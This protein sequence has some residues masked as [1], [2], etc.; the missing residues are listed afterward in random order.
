MNL[1]DTMWTLTFAAL[2]TGFISVLFITKEKRF[3]WY[4]AWGAILGFLI[5]IVS[6]S[7]GYYQYF[8]YPQYPGLGFPLT[9]S[10]AEGCAVSVTIFLFDRFIKPRF[11]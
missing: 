11:S 4:F 5:D 1:T 7:S 3:F 6:V 2:V 8:L 9:V 10:L